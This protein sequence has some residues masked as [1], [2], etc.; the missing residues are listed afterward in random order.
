MNTMEIIQ[1]F[2]TENLF[3]KILNLLIKF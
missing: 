3:Q 2:E 1:N